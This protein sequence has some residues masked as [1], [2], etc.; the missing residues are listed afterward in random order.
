[1]Y[2]PSWLWNLRLNRGCVARLRPALRR[3]RSQGRG[4][5]VHGSEADGLDRSSG[6]RGAAFQQEGR[7]QNGKRDIGKNKLDETRSLATTVGW[8]EKPLTQGFRR[9]KK[10]TIQSF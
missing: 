8:L 4:V 7:S 9:T 6:R 5:C 3:T 2:S 10:D 1:M